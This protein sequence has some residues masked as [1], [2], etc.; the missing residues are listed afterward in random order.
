MRSQS[1]KPT[2]LSARVSCERLKPGPF[3][4]KSFSQ[5]G[6]DI[7]VLGPRRSALGTPGRPPTPV[8]VTMPDDQRR[9]MARLSG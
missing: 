7:V 8:G 6:K 1:E 2:A 5:L 4:G 3:R 9:G